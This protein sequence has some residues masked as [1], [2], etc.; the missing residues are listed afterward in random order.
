MTMCLCVSICGGI[1]IFTQGGEV[2]YIMTFN[3]FH[4][5]HYTHYS[6]KNYSAW[7]RPVFH[8][9][10]SEMEILWA[11]LLSTAMKVRECR[12]IS[13]LLF[14]GHSLRTWYSWLSWDFLWFGKYGRKKGGTVCA[15]K[16]LA[17]CNHS[18]VKK[19]N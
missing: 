1:F 15:L 8:L 7:A 12:I 13:P 19:W 4:F 2:P 18:E 10:L 9:K 6:N 3:P 14:T 17:V 16:G 11:K 5:M